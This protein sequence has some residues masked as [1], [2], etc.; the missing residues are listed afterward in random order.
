LDAEIAKL[1]AEHTALMRGWADLTNPRAKAKADAELARLDD[2]IKELEQQQQDAAEVVVSQFREMHNLQRAIDTVKAA[3]R[4]ETGERA[5][6]QR[7]QAVRSVIQRIE[8]TFTATGETGGGWGK[9]NA[10]LVKVT[11]Y[12]VVGDP[13][14]FSAGGKGTLLYSSAHS[15]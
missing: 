11:I 15:F 3:M 2:R 7:A 12:P 6:R 14:S 1:D 8:C 10:R 5:L 13:V 9:K 4:S